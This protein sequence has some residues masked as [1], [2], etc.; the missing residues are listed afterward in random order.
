MKI[1]VHFTKSLCVAR[2]YSPVNLR[3]SS[4]PKISIEKESKQ[5][6]KVFYPRV[7]HHQEHD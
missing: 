2:D 5:G 6:N 7:L 3:L 4:R 1:L